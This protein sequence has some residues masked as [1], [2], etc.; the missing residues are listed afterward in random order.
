MAEELVPGETFEGV[1]ELKEKRSSTDLGKMRLKVSE[2]KR[3][4][5]KH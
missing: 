1:Y 5:K 2:L 4:V 3:S